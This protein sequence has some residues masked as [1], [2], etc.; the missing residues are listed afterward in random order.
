MFLQIVYFLS[1]PIFALYK[2]IGLLNRTYK[3][4]NSFYDH[5][6]LLLFVI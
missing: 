3:Q 6:W 2:F 4:I 1:L 5:F